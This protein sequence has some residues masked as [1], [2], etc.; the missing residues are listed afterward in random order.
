MVAL[1]LNHLNFL[2]ASKA[3]DI[4]LW[5]L[6]QNKDVFVV[7]LFFLCLHCNSAFVKW[8][9]LIVQKMFSILSNNIVHQFPLKAFKAVYIQHKCSSLHF[10]LSKSFINTGLSVLFY[11]LRLFLL[12]HFSINYTHLMKFCFGLSL[13]HSLLKTWVIIYIISSIAII[14]LRPMKFSLMQSIWI[15]NVDHSPD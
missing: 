15:G 3:T 6:K 9:I 10:C 7:P 12:G 5:L 1:L 11:C 8:Y 2:F 14:F 13:T 4:L